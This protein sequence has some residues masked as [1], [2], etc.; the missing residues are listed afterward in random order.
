MVVYK[1]VKRLESQSLLIEVFIPSGPKW[2]IA[3]EAKV[4]IP[5]HRGLHSF[6]RS[7]TRR[8]KMK[9]S[10]SLLIEVFIPSDKEV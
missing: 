7:P 4:A 3:L 10:Q 6:L 1:I 9:W 8:F 2:A 5:S